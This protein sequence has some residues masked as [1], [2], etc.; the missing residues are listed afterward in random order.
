MKRE[1]GRKRG[2]E[3]RKNKGKEGRREDRNLRKER[4]R[5]GGERK[6]K[7]ETWKGSEA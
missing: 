4:E 2:E 7:L 3:G 1:R 5:N 6:L